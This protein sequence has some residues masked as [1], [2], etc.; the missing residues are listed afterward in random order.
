MDLEIRPIVAEEFAAFA[1]VDG[2]TFG[3]PPDDQTIAANEPLFEFDRSRAVFDKGRIVASSGTFSFVLTLPGLTELPVAGVSWVGVMP[4]HRR[5]GLLRALMGQLHDDAVNRGEAISVLQ[6][7]ETNIYGR[8]G[9]GPGT[10]LV[11]WEIDAGRAGFAVPPDTAHTLEIMDHQRAS[12]VLPEVFERARRQ[13]PGCLN[14]SDARWRHVLDRPNQVRDGFSPRFYVACSARPGS[15]DGVAVYRLKPKWHAEIP[16]YTLL[17]REMIATTDVAAAALW[18]FCFNVDLVT[19]VKAQDR[20]IDEPVRWLLAE[21]RQLRVTEMTDDLWIRLLDISAA[22]GA[23][24]YAVEDSLVLQ[25]QDP[26]CP[27]NSDRYALEGS[28]SGAQCR[29]TTANADLAIDVADL[30]AAYLGG[31]RFSTLARARRADELR[32][33]ALRLADAMFA[34]EPAPWCA[35]HF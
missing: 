5:R 34:C 26:F 7:S 33:G 35:T 27:R 30:G 18:D 24:R 4:T 28:A 15:I 6:C 31:V 21:P 10:Y 23:R 19:R 16:A 12:E 32:P 3:E 20:P 14:R 25:V 8:V 9:Y 17:V 13:R 2:A 29:R 22:L 1:W 11:N